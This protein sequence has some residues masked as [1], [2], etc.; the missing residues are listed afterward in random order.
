M[1]KLTG[2]F[3]AYLRKSRADLEAEARGQGETLA[4]HARLIDE[5]ARRLGIRVSEIYREVVSGDTIA[6]RPEMRRLLGDVNAGKW[7]GVLVVDVDRLARGDSIDQGLILQSFV[8]SNTLIVT[9]D[10][11]YDPRDDAD[12]EFFEIKLF[13]SRREY[14]MIKSGCSGDAWPPPRT[15]ATWAPA[16]STATSASSSRAARAG[17]C[18][19]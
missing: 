3:C 15:A 13:F 9:P 7:D 6:E 19:S 2:L 14:S 10:K 17:P 8:Y 18:R 4:R 11:I 1:D 16:R 12:Q 5:T